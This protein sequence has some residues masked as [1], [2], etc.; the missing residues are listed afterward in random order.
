MK[1]RYITPTLTC[2]PMQPTTLLAG[3][4]EV[5]YNAENPSYGEG[6]GGALGKWYG[7]DGEYEDTE[8]ETSNFFDNLTM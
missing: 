8:N 1:K 2:I 4:G 5:E 7:F 6:E 3:S